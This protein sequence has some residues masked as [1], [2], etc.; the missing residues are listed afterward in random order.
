MQTNI[1]SKIV[2]SGSYIPEVVVKN[3]DFLTNEFYNDKGE[4]IPKSNAEITSKLQEITGIIERRYVSDNLVTSDIAH[5]AAEDA[6][7]SSGIDRE[8]LDCII[9]AHNFG[10]VRNDNRRSDFVPSIAARVKQKLQIENPSCVVYDVAFGCPG[11][12]MGVI[13]ADSFI[14]SGIAK[15]AMVIGS[16]T[17]SRISDPADIDSMIYSDG[18]GVVILE[19]FE[20][21]EP[22]GILI[23]STR[24]DTLNHAKLLH[25]E[26]SYNPAV[27]KGD[28]YLKMHGHKL[29]KYAIQTV[30]IVIKECI[31]KL[32]IKVTEINKVFIHQAN[33]KLDIEILNRLFDIYGL[34]DKFIENMNNIMPMTISWL[35]NSSVATIPTLYDFFMKGRLENHSPKS[36]E[37]YLFASVGA[38]MNV[39]C[40]LYR[41]P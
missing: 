10:D 35:G 24:S 39:N 11:W 21:S 8:T 13:Q 26:K 37:L 17:L 30:P 5:L 4:K 40:M 9:V 38:G 34:K 36:D 32:N 1:Y 22:K 20:S 25:M 19:A 15:R 41:V 29:Y 3:T 31:E 16:E 27:D 7:D 18:A 14:K 12:L 6:L 33:E 2:G 23:H 28:L